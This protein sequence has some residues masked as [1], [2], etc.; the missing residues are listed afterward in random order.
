MIADVFVTSCGYGPYL[1]TGF[2]KI[3]RSST[4]MNKDVD[5]RFIVL[6][7]T[8]RLY[9]DLKLKRLPAIKTLNKAKMLTGSELEKREIAYAVSRLSRLDDT[10]S[11][12]A[13]DNVKTRFAKKFSDFN[14]KR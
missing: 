4:Y 1:E 6:S 14:N 13:I 10:L 3:L 11:E 9:K 2:R 8:L 5:D 12:G 7:W